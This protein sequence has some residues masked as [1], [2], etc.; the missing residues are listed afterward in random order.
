MEKRCMV[1][2]NF[3]NIHGMTAGTKKWVKAKR[4][5]DGIAPAIEGAENFSF[6]GMNRIAE[7]RHLVV[8]FGIKAIIADHF[9]MFVRNMAD[10][11]LDK[12]QGGKGFMN[13]NAVFVAV[14]MKGDGLA[15]IGVNPGSGN[16]GSSQIAANI[17]GNLMGI[18]DIGFGINI[19]PLGAEFIN[20]GFHGIKRRTETGGQMIKQS[21]PEGKAEEVEIEMTDFA[22]GSPVTGSPF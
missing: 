14:V 3:Q 12:V 19:K 16:D 4:K 1:V 7:V 18:A 15:I 21:G 13:K 2:K 5:C 9:K 17:V 6:S 22:P 20:Q 11:P 8:V 10:K